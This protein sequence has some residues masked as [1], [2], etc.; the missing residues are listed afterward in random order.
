MN[1]QTRKDKYNGWTA[2]DTIMLTNKLQLDII[3]VKLNGL[4]KTYGM[5]SRKEK[6]FLSFTLYEDF[7]K[8][9]QQYSVNRVTEKSI[10]N[11]HNL[12]DFSTVINDANQFY[13]IE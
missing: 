11:Q 12:M 13:G 1:T 4:M 2:T 3:T 9:Y 8:V 10:L 5:V 7:Y 6:G